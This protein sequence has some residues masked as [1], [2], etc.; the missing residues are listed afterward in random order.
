MGKYCADCSN[1]NTGKKKADGI[2]ECKKNK[3]FMPGNMPACDKFSQ[4]YSRNWYEK[5]KLY[6]DG[7]KN[8]N[9][10]T[11]GEVSILGPIILLILLLV[12]KLLKVI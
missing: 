5:E 3:K 9:G 10:S 1:F 7:K 6:D 11:P 2:C 4:S 12:L 8:S